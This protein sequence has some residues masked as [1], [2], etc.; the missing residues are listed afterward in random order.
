MILA[1]EKRVLEERLVAMRPGAGRVT[2][3]GSIP[4]L[5]WLE[6]KDKGFKG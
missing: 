5:A 4:Q 6:K 1:E 3:G 2:L